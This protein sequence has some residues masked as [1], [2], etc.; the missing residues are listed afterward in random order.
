[1]GGRCWGG[2]PRRGRDAKALGTVAVLTAQLGGW[3]KP[4]THSSAPG[5][6]GHTLTGRGHEGEGLC[7]SLLPSALAGGAFEKA[8]G[9]WAPRNGIFSVCPVGFAERLDVKGLHFPSNSEN[10]T[11]FP[12][13]TQRVSCFSLKLNQ[14]LKGVCQLKEKKKVK[15]IWGDL[16]GEGSLPSPELKE[17]A[18]QRRPACGPHLVSTLR[19]QWVP[20]QPL[21]PGW[22]WGAG[23]SWERRNAR[24]VELISS[25]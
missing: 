1:M 24:W 17:K 19:G 10:L 18:G 11:M 6:A 20:L 9:Q 4:L 16:I 22:G 12:V 7:L 5:R 15:S 2:A 8:D 21:T 3:A 23:V 25:E 13:F 14:N